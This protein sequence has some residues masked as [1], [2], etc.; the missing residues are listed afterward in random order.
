MHVNV[1]TWFSSLSA[2]AKIFYEFIISPIQAVN[3]PTQ[4]LLILECYHR[5]NSW[6]IQCCYY[7]GTVFRRSVS[8]LK[9]LCDLVRW[10]LQECCTRKLYRTEVSSWRF[11][12]KMFL[13]C[14]KSEQ[15]CRFIGLH[16]KTMFLINSNWLPSIFVTGFVVSRLHKLLPRGSVQNKP[17]HWMLLSKHQ[18]SCH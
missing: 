16:G 1:F 14:Y 8:N 4:I 17:Q 7:I 5:H 11:N 15:V 6:P 10:I 3:H 9:H 2:H 18:T 13:S 12:T